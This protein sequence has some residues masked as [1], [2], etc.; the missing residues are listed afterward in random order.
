MEEKIIARDIKNEM[1]RIMILN[2]K[3]NHHV[4]FWVHKKDDLVE[5]SFDWYM[6]WE[7]YATDQQTKP[8]ELRKTIE[9]IFIKSLIKV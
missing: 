1:L 8:E 5:Y 2:E 3:T 4:V 9:S 6:E 7:D